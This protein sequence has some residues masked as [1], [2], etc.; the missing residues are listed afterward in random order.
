[1]LGS[2]VAGALSLVGSA[3]VYGDVV[4]RRGIV[5]R[6]VDRAL[7]AVA[8]SLLALVI[9]SVVPAVVGIVAAVAALVSSSFG[10]AVLVFG[11][12]L[13]APVVAYVGFHLVLAVPVV[14]REGRGPVDALRRSWELVKGA[15]VWVL[16][17]VVV[18]AIP[19]VIVQQLAELAIG[20][21][22]AAD[23]VGWA[24]ASAVDAMLAS[25]LFGVGVGV[26]YASRAPEDIV[27]PD[28]ALSEARADRDVPPSPS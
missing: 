14:M 28:V 8:S 12:V 27:P 23:F 4:D 1:L 7:D 22:G 15:W 16:G 19:P 10:F 17:L 2:V 3:A 11:T 25:V 9:V 5:R 21:G 24:V 13:V 20:R 18:C 6:A 26:I